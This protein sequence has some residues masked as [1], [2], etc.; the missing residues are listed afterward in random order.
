MATVL[1]QLVTWE[2][3]FRQREQLGKNTE[4]WHMVHVCENCVLEW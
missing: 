1:T 3:N 2:Y 4:E